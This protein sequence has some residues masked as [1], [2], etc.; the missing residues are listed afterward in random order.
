V[1]YES[2]A[3]VVPPLSPED[4]RHFN[5]DGFLLR[6]SFFDAEE[7]QYLERAYEDDSAIQRRTV[8]LA[9]GEGGQTE[10]A[11]WNEPG[12]D[13]FGAVARCARM[14][15]A[16]EQLLGDEVYHYHSKI[17]VK[18][19]G[20]GGVWL[21][22][23]DYGYW[24]GNGCLYPDMLTVAIPL[25][26][27]NSANGCLQVV[28]TTNRMGR[29]EHLRIGEQTGADPERVKEILA[30]VEPQAFE[31]SPGD[32]L[33]FHCNTLHGSAPNL[34]DVPRH[35]LLVAYNSRHN[36]P[37]RAH[38]HPGYHPI[39]RLP[40]SAIKERRNLRDGESRMFMPARGKAGGS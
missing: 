18:Q 34:S 20:G 9:D 5:N 29:I 12:E 8:R 33:F 4:F 28:P 10:I 36:E 13:V 40:D 11:L 38:H 6:R 25:T 39:D 2:E 23:Q 15:D 35:L 7:V 27:M 1:T 22:H 37:Y 17:N 24:Y 31:A 3:A 19:P 21:W 16:A 26:P 14:V 30:R 32:V